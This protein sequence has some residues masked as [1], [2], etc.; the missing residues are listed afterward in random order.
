MTNIY[1]KNKNDVKQSVR[2]A[3]GIERRLRGESSRLEELTPEEERMLAKF[4]RELAMK[5]SLSLCVCV[6]GTRVRCWFSR[7][8][9]T[10]RCDQA[11]L[12]GTEQKK[13]NKKNATTVCTIP[14]PP[15]KEYIYIYICIRVYYL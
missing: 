10:A 11:L 5:V 8:L 4:L 7:Y 9:P 15:K 1:L 3:R 2:E 14:P 6:L 13:T 12:G